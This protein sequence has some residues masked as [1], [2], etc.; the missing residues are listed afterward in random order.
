MKK[1]LLVIILILPLI[2]LY[3]CKRKNENII[4]LN[5]SQLVY[6]SLSF[7]KEYKDIAQNT[8]KLIMI[9]SLIAVLD[10]I[11][12]D[13]LK[14][15]NVFTGKTQAFINQGRARG[16]VLGAFDIDYY[17]DKNSLAVLDISNSKILTCAID[18]INIE[19]YYPFNCYDLRVSGYSYFT[20][21]SILNSSVCF[22]GCFDNIR[23]LQYELNTSQ[24]IDSIKYFP[25]INDNVINRFINQAY[26][27]TIQSNQLLNKFVIGCR[28]ADQL[29][30]YDLKEDKVLYI[31]GPLKFEPDYQ[32]VN[33]NSGK[34]LS[35]SDNERK[36]YVDVASDSEYIYALYSGRTIQ[37]GK[38]AYGK[39]I[40]KF[41]WDGKYIMSYLLDRYILSFDLGADGCIYAICDEGN[42]LQYMMD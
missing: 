42:I 18:S 28:Y 9:D 2:L 21:M 10:N 27:G 4:I 5:D 16:E 17:P 15:Y 20:N 30:I 38:S 39:E 35:H 26:M 11:S 40:R 24:P 23:C 13:K 7:I 12:T 33:T 31:K 1:K 32:I 19:G 3:S 8:S 36:G 41:T 29:E 34:V 25:G 37:E 22:L 14:I 6:K